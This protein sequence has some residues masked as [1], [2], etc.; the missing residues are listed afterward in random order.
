MAFGVGSIVMRKIASSDLTLGA[1]GQPPAFG[2]VETYAAPAVSVFWDDGLYTV[3]VVGAIDDLYSVTSATRSAYWGK[4]VRPST[5]SDDYRAV[6]V[7]M[8]RRGSA[9]NAERALIRYLTG[10]SAGSFAE[11]D[12]SGLTVI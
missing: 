10:P 9:A 12:A 2:K 1:C 5:Y 3:T 11:F 8:Y 4:I 7:A 6:V